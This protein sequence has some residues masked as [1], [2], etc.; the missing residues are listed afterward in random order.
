L[1]I[2]TR[3]GVAE[4]WQ[5]FLR[6][7]LPIL[8]TN[9]RIHHILDPPFPEAKPPVQQKYRLVV[10]GH[11]LLSIQYGFADQSLRVYFQD[12]IH[13]VRDRPATGS[14]ASQLVSIVEGIEVAHAAFASATLLITV[15][16]LGIITAWR[17]SIKGSGFRRGEAVLAREATL[18]GARNVTCIAVSTP[19]S[20]LVTGSDVG[21]CV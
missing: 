1:P 20:L 5:L 8:E 15:S 7:A 21:R 18:C 4:H 17:L 3:F 14:N 13:K 9:T 19:W 10:P 16:Q 11:P 12:N 2:G 6:S